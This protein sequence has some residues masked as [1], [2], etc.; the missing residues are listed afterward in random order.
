[1]LL[2]KFCSIAYWRFYLRN[3]IFKFGF[4]TVY[5]LQCYLIGL[6]DWGLQ[7]S[8][9]LIN[10][11]TVKY[12][13]NEHVCNEFTHIVKWFY[14]FPYDRKLLDICNI[15]NCFLLE[16]HYNRILLYSYRSSNLFQLKKKIQ[17]KPI[18]HSLF[19]SLSIKVVNDVFLI[20]VNSETLFGCIADMLWIC[21][22][23]YEYLVND[24]MIVCLI[25]SP[26]WNIYKHHLIFYYFVFE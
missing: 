5:L 11:C 7:N 25:K 19:Q 18:Y 4:L 6:S 3:G 17:L 15:T 26:S 8:L 21:Y 23:P 20:Y 22:L 1:M 24:F 2:L 14:L 13:Y 16:V 9:S 10:W 12:G